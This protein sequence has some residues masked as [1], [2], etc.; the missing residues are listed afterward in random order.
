MVNKFEKVMKKLAVLV[1]NPAL[2]TDCSE[3]IPGRLAHILITMNV[4]HNRFVEPQPFTG[5]ATIPAGHSQSEIEQAVSSATVVDWTFQHELMVM[6]GWD[7]SV[8][9]P[10]SR[11]S[12]SLRGLQ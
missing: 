11:A 1:H 8:R 3:V 10:L 5:T 7:Y 6:V 2:L 4:V 9:R 12:Q